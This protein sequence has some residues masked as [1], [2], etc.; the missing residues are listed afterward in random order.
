M[1]RIMRMV[2][3]LAKALTLLA[4]SNLLAADF[5][6]G[7]T[8]DLAK[9]CY[10]NY[11]SYAS[12]T[13]RGLQSKYS[14]YPAERSSEE[15]VAAEIKIEFTDNYGE[16]TSGRCQFD[17]RSRVTCFTGVFELDYMKLPNGGKA[18]PVLCYEEGQRF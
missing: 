14:Y 13:D 12:E 11:A 5:S 2:W 7:V 4:S 10:G 9:Q 3:N 6:D 8:K 16:K 18:F 15:G 17:S 1:I